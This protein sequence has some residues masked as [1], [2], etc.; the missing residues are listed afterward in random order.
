MKNPSGLNRLPE[1]RLLSLDVY[2][3]FAMLLLVAEV[4]EAYDLMVSNSPKRNSLIQNRTS[5]SSFSMARDD[6]LEHGA[7][8]LY[9]HQQKGVCPSTPSHPLSRSF[10]RALSADQPWIQLAF[11]RPFLLCHR[12]PEIPQVV[13]CYTRCRP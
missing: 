7:G 10:P 12:H 13:S 4:T 11:S 3:G 2:R 6:T 9:V 1:G 5:V 8:I